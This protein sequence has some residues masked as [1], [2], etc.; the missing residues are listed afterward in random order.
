MARKRAHRVLLVEDD[1]GDAH[2]TQLGLENGP[3]DEVY[4]LVRVTRYADALVHLAA[5]RF[6]VVLLDL[7]LPDEQGLEVVT[8]LTRR[9]PEIPILVLSGL[10][11]ERVALEAVLNGAQD[12]LIK[13][14]G[15]GRLLR[16]AI[17][18]AIE[19]KRVERRLARLAT[20]DPLTGLANRTLFE[21]RLRQA[22]DRAERRDQQIAV[23]YIDLDGF[24]GVNDRH[25]HAA[26][27]QL[28]RGVAARLVQIVR[29]TDP[30]ARI[31]GDEFVVLLEGVFDQADVARVAEKLLAE[32]QTPFQV[33]G[34]LVTIGASFGIAFGVTGRETPSGLTNLADDAMYRVKV[35]GGFAYTFAMQQSRPALRA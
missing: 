6:D 2:L 23:I 10:D 13:G 29:R 12:Y 27:D 11:D 8:D 14:E 26:G 5:R 4:P 35:G 19:R 20:H 7:M 17:R 33:C 31:G 3:A 9:S 22:L 1:D 25:G 18:H 21:D 15:S 30:V 16:R 32:L 24:K 34:M 28:L